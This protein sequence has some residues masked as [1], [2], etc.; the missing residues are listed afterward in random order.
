MHLEVR[1]REPHRGM[2]G[3][4]L[5]WASL[6]LF[7]SVKDILG[8]EIRDHPR[9][10]A[11]YHGQMP[12]RGSAGEAASICEEEKNSGDLTDV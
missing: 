4:C 5:P 8:L 3:A 6:P 9:R 10:R 12:V 1:H 11:R 2:M 7:T